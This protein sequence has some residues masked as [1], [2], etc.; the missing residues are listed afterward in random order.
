MLGVTATTALFGSTALT[1]ANKALA[2]GRE[3]SFSFTELE[4]GNDENHHIADGYDADVLIRWG[5]KLFPDAPDFDP[6]NQSVESQ[7]QQFGYNNDYVGFVPLNADETRGVLCVNHEYTNEEVMFPGVGR[8]DNQDFAG[9]TRELVEIEM[10]AHGGSVFEIAKNADNKW[11][12][13]LDSPY[14]RR[15]TALDTLMTVSGPAAG[16]AKL[17]N[18]RRSVRH[19]HCRHHQQLRRRHHALGYVSDGRGELPRLFLDRSG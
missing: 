7:L 8:Q 17:K 2:N 14:N 12:V 19:G 5:D 3:A 15:I 9:M 11:E 10:A 18:R 1:A 6:Q 16:H 13:V 4:S